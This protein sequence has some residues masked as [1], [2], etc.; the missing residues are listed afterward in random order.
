MGF[1]VED[2]EAEGERNVGGG[3]LGELTRQG[4]GTKRPSVSSPNTPF[5]TL[6][7]QRRNICFHM[8]GRHQAT[9]TCFTCLFLF[10]G[11]RIYLSWCNEQLVL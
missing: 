1:R 5:P 10:C 4:R 9:L 11:P 6:A 8:L 2:G 3:G 7:I